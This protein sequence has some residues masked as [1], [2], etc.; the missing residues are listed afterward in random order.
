MRH[1]CIRD[2]HRYVSIKMRVNVDIMFLT[3]FS[4]HRPEALMVFR[5]S[6][7]CSTVSNPLCLVSLMRGSQIQVDLTIG[8]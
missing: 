4:M 3:N 2:V 1:N 8:Q 7:T 6:K 5:L